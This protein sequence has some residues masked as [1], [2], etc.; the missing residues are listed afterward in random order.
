MDDGAE[1]VWKGLKLLIR[2]LCEFPETVMDLFEWL[3]R[4]VLRHVFRVKKEVGYWTA[5]PIGLCFIV[6]VGM[7]GF[8][9]AVAL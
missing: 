5:M 8:L 1:G 3:G 2:G 4:K 6:L 7:A 9:I